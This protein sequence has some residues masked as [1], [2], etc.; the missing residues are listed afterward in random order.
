MSIL[1]RRCALLCGLILVSAGGSP[2]SAQIEL[3]WESP[4]LPDHPLAGRIH[5]ANGELDWSALIE[6][7]ANSRYV[8]I[9]EK[10]DNPD[11]HQIE[12]LLIRALYQALGDSEPG[13]LGIVME[14]LNDSQ[15]AGLKDVT[16]QLAAAPGTTIDG[17]QLRSQL[18][19]PES[20]WRWSDYGEVISWVVNQ[21]LPLAA[22]NISTQQMKAVYSK[23]IDE[24]FATA[25]EARSA[26]EDSL[27]EQVF[28]GHCGLMPEESLAPMVDIQLV[29]DS[30]MAN[31]LAMTGTR[32]SVLVAGKAHI[33][34]DS[35]VP[36]HLQRLGDDNVLTVAMIEVDTVR[37]L[38][39]D[40]AAMALFDVLIFTPVAN[41]RDYCADLEKSMHKK[42]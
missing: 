9:G 13:S 30:S 27:L 29:K 26:L 11:H 2:V 37:E 19:W 24:S 16:A 28:D 1:L 15:R 14:M 39:S 20:G 5:D 23:G 4:H 35:G 36:Q 17:D 31:S 8:L 40:Y 18:G 42:H 25:L 41:Q 33:R 3:E 12:L 32:H 34:K 21:R 22:G 6:R 10:H 7:M 38:A